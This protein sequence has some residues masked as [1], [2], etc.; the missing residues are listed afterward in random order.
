VTA[1]PTTEPTTEIVEP[2]HALGAELIVDEPFVKCWMEQV[3]PG[4]S[5]PAHTHRHPWITVVL[6][7]ATGES[8]TPGGELI[9][10]GTTHTGEV[11]FNGSDR[12]PFS[13]YLTNTS[14]NTLVM[15]AVEMRIP[16]AATCETDC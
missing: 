2:W 1:E 9:A 6:A 15:L 4:E 7:G 12:L 5:R 13:H 14:D 16:S 11:R 3:P 10:A 8:R